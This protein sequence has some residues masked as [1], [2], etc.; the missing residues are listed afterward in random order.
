MSRLQLRVVTSEAIPADLYREILTLCNAAYREDL[1][2]LFRT[3][4]SCTH[5]IGVIDDRVV[6]HAMSGFIS[7]C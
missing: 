5:V 3:F 6:S 4:D 2:E 1:T 7:T